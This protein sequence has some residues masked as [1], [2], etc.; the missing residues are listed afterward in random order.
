MIADINGTMLGYTRAGSGVPLICLHGGMGL[1][2][3]SLRT[4]GIEGLTSTGFE[5][6]LFDQRGHGESSKSPPDYL[7]HEQWSRDVIGLA[8]HLG[9]DQF[10]L[11]GHSYGGFIALEAAIHHPGR[12]SH[13]ILVSTSAGPVEVS[14]PELH[15]DEELQMFFQERWPHFFA[16]KQKHW[17]YFKA[18]RF[19]VAPFN[20]AFQKELPKYDLSRKLDRIQSETLLIVGE[21]DGYLPAMQ[22]I[23]RLLP[24]SK[25]EML[26]NTGHMSFLES[27]AEFQKAIISFFT[28]R[29]RHAV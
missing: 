27:E 7:T 9:W 24:N 23:A 28:S 29:G 22:N 19:S 20:A 8:D 12:L 15:D 18:Q 25:L 26:P 14:F 11:L 16:G 3:G 6:V 17:E 10:A 13:L 21:Q 5:V 4:P 1:D 2:S